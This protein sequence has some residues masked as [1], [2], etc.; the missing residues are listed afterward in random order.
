[1]ARSDIASLA[2]LAAASGPFAI[3]AREQSPRPAEI[4]E[5]GEQ[6]QSMLS[7]RPLDSSAWLDLARIRLASGEGLDQVASA[8]AL[9]SLVGPNE[10]ANMA[11]RATFGIPLWSALPPG[12][13]RALLSDLVG[14]WSGID[15]AGRQA[16]RASLMVMPGAAKES[17][18]AALLLAGKP[19]VGIVA[20]LF[21]P[22]GSGP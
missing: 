14:G 18:R 17:L 22:E 13:R 19:A 6:V 10:E 2:Q 9:S 12:S 21:P 7:A 15:E 16:L 1:M 11:G 8:L 4:A 3:F 20:S 5:Q